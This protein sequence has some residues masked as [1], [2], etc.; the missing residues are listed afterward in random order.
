MDRAGLPALFVLCAAGCLAIMLFFA[1][2]GAIFH[3]PFNLRMVTIVA[4]CCWAFC[5]RA[6]WRRREWLDEG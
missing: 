4:I 5:L 1:V 3:A 2:I 6:A